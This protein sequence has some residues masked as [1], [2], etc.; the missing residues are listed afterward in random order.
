MVEMIIHPSR[1][2]EIAHVIKY[3]SLVIICNLHSY[4]SDNI[5]VEFGR[6]GYPEP[7]SKI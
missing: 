2:L 4:T 7:L 3:K 6:T 1:K 5:Q